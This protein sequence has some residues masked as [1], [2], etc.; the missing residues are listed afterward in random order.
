MFINSGQKIVFC[1]KASGFKELGESMF[2]L[3][4]RG[5]LWYSTQEYCESF[6]NAVAMLEYGK[7]E[8]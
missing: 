6:S 2:F 7:R 3:F 8:R 5:I 4:I 1:L